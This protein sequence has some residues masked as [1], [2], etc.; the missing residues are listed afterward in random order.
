MENKMDAAKI[1]DID[2]PGAAAA[3]V[4]SDGAKTLDQL[5]ADVG[6]TFVS[7]RVVQPA[8]I[9]YDWVPVPRD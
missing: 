6:G 7:V 5:V 8:K 4:I 2:Y 1:Y 3:M 9:E